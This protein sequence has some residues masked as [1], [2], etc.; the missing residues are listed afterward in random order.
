VRAPAALTKADSL[1]AHARHCGA[2]QAEFQVALTLG[3]AYEL[4][5]YLGT[6][7]LGVPRNM[8]ALRVDIAEAKVAGDPWL[9]LKDWRLNGFELVRVEAL[10]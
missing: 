5:D 6:G 9:V 7:A 10:H 4:L 3:E 8:A 1:L 2:P